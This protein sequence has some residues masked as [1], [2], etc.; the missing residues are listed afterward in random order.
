L[1]QQ[2]QILKKACC[3][4]AT[5]KP[6]EVSFF[7]ET[8]LFTVQFISTM[9]HKY[10]I[11]T[12][13][14][15]AAV[16][17]FLAFSRPDVAPNQAVQYTDEVGNTETQWYAGSNQQKIFALDTLTTAGTTTITVPWNMASPYQ[18]QY[19]FKMRKIGVTPNVKVVLDE[20][21][22]A[23]SALWS[24][25]DSVSMV[26]AD[27]TKLN[28]R[29]RGSVTYGSFHRLRFVKVGNGGVAR[30]TELVIK[31]TN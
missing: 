23:N 9:K 21:N 4:S 22:A 19:F 28:F 12:A 18:Y 16:T 27:S 31:P 17:C 8:T 10:F 25:I 1:R 30:N 3:S 7:I 29:L 11:Y 14:F 24:A 6:S 5:S 2:A 20:R 26:G 15:C 13:L